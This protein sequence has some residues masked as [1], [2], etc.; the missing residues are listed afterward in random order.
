M[1]L[2]NE[3]EPS[4]EDL[5]FTAL[6]MLIGEEGIEFCYYEQ[7]EDWWELRLLTRIN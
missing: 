6:C 1:K 7:D 4:L 2:P 3:I 5:I